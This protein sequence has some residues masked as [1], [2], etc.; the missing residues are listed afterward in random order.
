MSK[1]HEIH[2]LLV[3]LDSLVDTLHYGPY[4]C[5]WWNFFPE[6]KSDRSYDCFPIRLGQKMCTKLNRHDF[7][8]SIH[9]GNRKYAMLPEFQCQGSEFSNT[10]STASEVI[11]TVYKLIFQNETRY[12][13]PMVIGWNNEKIVEELVQDVE[14]FPFT[15]SIGQYTI[16][17]YSIGF[18]MHQDWYKAGNGYK[19]S[20]IHKY[21]QKPAI[22]VS[23]IENDEYF[24]DIYYD[25]KL[26][27]TFRE[28]T[29]DRVWKVSKLIQKFSGKQ[30]FGL[31]DPLICKLLHEYWIPKYAPE[32]WNDLEIM[33]TL[34]NYYLRCR[35][36]AS[37]WTKSKKA[38]NDKE[39]LQCLFGMGFLATI[40]AHIP[41]TS[42]KFWTCF[43]HSLDDNKKTCNGKHRVLSIIANDFTYEKMQENLK[44]E[45]HTISESRKHAILNGYGAP[46]LEKPISQAIKR[47]VKLGSVLESGEDIEMAIKDISGTYVA[48]LM[49]NRSQDNI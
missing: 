49:P 40:P 33:N 4:S 37:L 15:T 23:R 47:Y 1:C 11:S 20:L 9:H 26:Y 22:F 10:G 3:D 2:I 48:N 6:K 19:A 46:S 21:L 39:I 17:I 36:L 18:S 35:T 16:F 13:G 32:Q 28:A 45:T 7:Y 42:R 34:F 27:K 44:V 12:S 24:I 41:N 43:K 38:N 31:E 14:F 30:L 25:C 8:V 29:P 5:Y